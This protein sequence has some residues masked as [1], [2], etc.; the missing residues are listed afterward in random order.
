MGLNQRLKH[1]IYNNI[2]DF[3]VEDTN[4]IADLSENIA[5][6]EVNIET[7]GMMP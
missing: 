2:S 1:P 5:E 4:R 3:M 7:L 6:E